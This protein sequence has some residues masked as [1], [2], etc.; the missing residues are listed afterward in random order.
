MALSKEKIAELMAK[1]NAP[2]KTG[3]GGRRKFDINDRSY[4]A[5]FAMEH[6]IY[7]RKTGDPAFCSNPDCADPRDKTYGQTIVFIGEKGV[8]RFCFLSGWLTTNS[9]QMSIDSHN[10]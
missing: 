7:D 8:C 10:G 2:R 3:T 5:W 1:K 9:N 4:Q 6:R